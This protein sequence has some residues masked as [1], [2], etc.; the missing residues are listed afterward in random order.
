MFVSRC[1]RLFGRT[2]QHR[3]GFLPQPGKL[4][5]RHALVIFIRPDLLGIPLAHPGNGVLWVVAIDHRHIVAFEVVEVT[6]RRH[7][8]GGFADPTLL[9]GKG[10]IKGCFLV[11]QLLSL[12]GFPLAMCRRR[13]RYGYCHKLTSVRYNLKQ[14]KL[15][16]FDEFYINGGL[17][18]KKAICCNCRESVRNEV[19]E[20]AVS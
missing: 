15:P 12:Y 1:N 7:G 19:V 8:K 14:C 5:I 20:R 9:G 13:N 3:V 4:F 18:F 6:R 17:L 2:A 11:F 16:V 10:D